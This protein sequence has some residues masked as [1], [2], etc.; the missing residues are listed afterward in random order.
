VTISGKGVII[1]GASHG[2]GRALAEELAERGARLV[3]VARRRAALEDV[4]VR[5]R[6]TGAEAHALCYDV[7]D[8]TA[9]YP[10]AGAAHAL[11]GEVDVVVHN[12]STLGP[13]PL[14]PLLDTECEDLSRVLEVNLL[15]PFRLSKALAGNM[16]LRG[17][18]TLLFI[19]SDAAVEAYPCWGAYGVSKAGL[20]HLARSLAA[21]L[22]ASGVRVLSVDPGEMDTRMHR[23][24]LPDADTTTL[25]APRDVAARIAGMLEDIERLGN[26]ARLL[27]SEWQKAS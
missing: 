21:E 3:L 2:L 18:G 7:G 22:G 26:G 10:L 5:L 4:A 11:L 1:T 8:K 17:A 19:S 23:D 14:R 15:G 9:V 6:R 20:D 24:A 16:A 25:A 13:T 27:A 12:A